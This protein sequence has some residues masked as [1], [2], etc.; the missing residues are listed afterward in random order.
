[1]SCCVINSRRLTQSLRAE[2]R[3]LLH[4]RHATQKD[5]RKRIIITGTDTG[6]VLVFWGG[7]LLSCEKEQ[8][9][10]ATE[11]KILSKCFFSWSL[12]SYKSSYCCN[13]RPAATTMIIDYSG[14][15]VWQCV[16]IVCSECADVWVVHECVCVT[17]I[18]VHVCLSIVSM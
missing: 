12:E 4:R 13:G 5:L 1:M 9:I 8:R 14:H 10:R 11:G 18:S 7:R 3:R 2:S 15:Q 6:T 17:G 16:F